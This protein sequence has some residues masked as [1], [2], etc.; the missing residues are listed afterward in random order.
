MSRHR[1]VICG[2][3]TGGHLFP[4]LVLGRTL[5]EKDPEIDVVF[6]GSDRPAE[7][8]LMARHGAAFIPL[9]V[10]GLKGRGLKSLRGLALLPFAFLRSLRILRRLRPGLVVGV[11]AYSS[12]P[13]GVAASWLKI[14]LL[15]LEQ[16]VVPGF[17]NRRLLKR[18]ARVAASFRETLPHLEG[19]GV[20]LGNP[21]REEFHLRPGKRPD[22]GFDLLVFG[23]SQGSRFLN[24]A[25]V[26]AL[27]YL[28][29]WKD[30]LRIVHQTG[31]ADLADVRR[32]YVESGW[33]GAV[34]E[35][36]FDDMPARFAAA[37]LVLARSGATTCAELIAA[38]KAS[39]LVPFAGAADDHQR[40]NAE[41]L[42]ASGGAEIILE[43]EWTPQALARMLGGLIEHPQRAAAMGEKLAP[44]AAEDPAGKTAALALDLMEK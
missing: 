28:D 24:R 36:F 35:R 37:D 44:L 20:F 3:G 19:K 39:I 7:R 11:G 17:T 4:A 21:V 5:R 2:G 43:S 30:R 23:G 27:P 9:R 22:G 12:G 26:G 13:V 8:E 32:G 10:E 1:V 18:A 40:K 42:A 15:L 6:I 38:R 25:V 41:V 29:R 14:P 16:N 34:V 33:T 31:T